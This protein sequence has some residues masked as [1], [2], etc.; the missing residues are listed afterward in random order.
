MRKLHFPA[1]LITYCSQIAVNNEM[2]IFVTPAGFKARGLQFQAPFEAS[3]LLL[4]KHQAG[5]Y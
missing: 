5:K 2:L 3:G 1:F 4:V